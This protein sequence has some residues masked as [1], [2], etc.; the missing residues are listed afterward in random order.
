LICPACGAEGQADPGTGYDGADLCPNCKADG[1]SFDAK[2]NLV[3]PESG[4]Y[5]APEPKRAEPLDE[6]DDDGIPF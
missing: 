2:G 4:L 1:W 3:D 5:V 6:W